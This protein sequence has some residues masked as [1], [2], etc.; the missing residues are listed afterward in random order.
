MAKLIRQKRQNKVSPIGVVKMTGLREMGNAMA[1]VG[2]FADE[3]RVEA[4]KVLEQT[5][6]NE[7]NDR[8]AYI[9]SLPDEEIDR[10]MADQKARE[11]E[12]KGELVY[13]ENSLGRPQ[14]LVS[15][16]IATKDVGPWSPSWMREWNR[17]AN[18]WNALKAGNQISAYV[19]QQEYDQIKGNINPSQF[20][21]NV[22]AYTDAVVRNTDMRAAGAVRMTVDAEIH[23]S[24]NRVLQARKAKDDEN[25]NIE[26][27]IHDRKFNSLIDEAVSENGV[28][29]QGLPLLVKGA[30]QHKLRKFS[31][32]QLSPTQIGLEFEK[33]SRKF[34][35]A[36]LLHVINNSLRNDATRKEI[37]ESQ[38]SVLENI[39]QVAV[40]NQM[41]PSL[42]LN[43]ETG[44]IEVAEAPFNEVYPTIAEQEL[45]LK[46]WRDLVKAK[47]DNV[48]TLI[49][50]RL[51]VLQNEFDTLLNNKRAAVLSKNPEMIAAADAA[52]NKFIN[53]DRTEDYDA[54]EAKATVNWI[55]SRAFAETEAGRGFAEQYISGAAESLAELEKIAPPSL[56]AQA[57]TMYQMDAEDLAKARDI[58][59]VKLAQRYQQQ[60]QFYLSSLNSK[61]SQSSEDLQNAFLTGEKLDHTK[62]L[63]KEAQ[64]I[65]N[66]L[67]TE[68]GLPTVNGI[69]VPF[70]DIGDNKF[71][72][73]KAIQ[74]TRMF[75]SVGVMPS[76]FMGQINK[77]LEDEQVPAAQKEAVNRWYRSVKDSRMFTADRLDSIF[78][79]KMRKALDYAYYAMGDSELPSG[80]AEVLRNQ[81]LI[82]ADENL[83]NKL[84][85]SGKI[86]P[87]MQKILDEKSDEWFGVKRIPDRMRSD[88]VKEMNIIRNSAKG[89]TMNNIDIAEL[90]ADNI[91]KKWKKS[92]WGIKG[93][94]AWAKDP[95]DVYYKNLETNVSPTAPL[96][97]IIRRQLEGREL[98][99]SFDSKLDMNTVSLPTDPAHVD[100][101]TQMFFVSDYSV[102]GRKIF[103]P[104]VRA[105]VG[106]Q[107]VHYA[108]MDK[109]YPVMIDL[110]PEDGFEAK[111]KEAI[112]AI[113]K[114]IERRTEMRDIATNK[115]IAQAALN[116]GVSEENLMHLRDVAEYSDDIAALSKEIRLLQTEGKLNFDNELF[117]MYR[118]NS[119]NTRLSDVLK[120]QNAMTE[121][122]YEYWNEIPDRTKAHILKK[123]NLQSL[124]TPIKQWFGI[125]L[126]EE[127]EQI[128]TTGGTKGT[129]DGF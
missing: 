38:E 50:V 58:G 42:Q 53:I 47:V 2:Q 108:V 101:T 30:W 35:E 81:K 116:N 26:H 21:E 83:F 128:E 82:L 90:A 40:G 12:G 49:K 122:E 79:S 13:Q 46:G 112:D 99:F 34:H 36:G 51:S 7:M 125:D 113:E 129:V 68:Q 43:V 110:S 16:Q 92:S 117:D 61:K 54:F 18:E 103:T 66:S 100:K 89:E 59:P 107:V 17:K 4:T 31:K 63:S 25:Y 121:G 119:I 64:S 24:Y 6:L 48:D 14:P 104:Y 94:D 39:A 60:I 52:W 27:A 23:K 29:D 75:S 11:A 78:G 5:K 84:T 22:A 44:D 1:Q 10:I 93:D 114:T 55:Q 91:E 73:Q 115:F 106:N 111:R 80:S 74:Y 3:V 56:R 102:D 120:L 45:A 105:K 87:D 118:A 88:W 62:K 97:T 19:A 95:I 72:F 20:K 8:M 67:A 96:K 57:K 98:T 37:Y 76:Q 123:Y 127:P 70:A 109:G 15:G 126:R 9:T 28:Y 77:I 41:L 33:F 86:N 65:V 32:D 85:P 69:Y 124:Y 71:E